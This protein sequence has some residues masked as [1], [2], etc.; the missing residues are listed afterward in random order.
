MILLIRLILLK[1]FLNYLFVSYF[2]FIRFSMN[3]FV[4]PIPSVTLLFAP[5]FPSCDN[6][7]IQQTV[8]DD[9]L[10]ACADLVGLSGLEPPTSRLSGALSNRLS[11]KPISSLGQRAQSVVFSSPPHALSVNLLT[12]WRWGESNSWPPACKA[13]A[14]PAELHPRLSQVKILLLFS[15]KEPSK[16]NNESSTFQL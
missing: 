6:L 4:C 13:G 2:T 9:Y 15:K 8:S 12:W 16:L 10:S 1:S 14:L 3:I 7:I 5:D 11:Y